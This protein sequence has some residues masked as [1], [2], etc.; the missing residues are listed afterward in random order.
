MH[1]QNI[2]LKVLLVPAIATLSLAGCMVGPRYHR[3]DATPQPPP[4]SY[5]ESPTQVQDPG[6]WKVA[7]P[8][9]AMLRVKWWEIYN[10]PELNG[11][12]DQ[13]NINNQNIKQYFENFMEARTL[14]AQAR[15][16]L[17]PTLGVGPSYTISRS[18]ANLR[19]AIS[20][21]TTSSGSSGS[22]TSTPNLHS[23][24]ISLPAEVTWEP[25]LWGKVRNTIHEA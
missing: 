15:S 18:S 16:Q 5:K 11:L 17:F 10:D 1:M 21:T 12:E 6:P 22:T 2:R 8:Q 4:P 20:A 19:N 3:P 23:T 13:L 24:L 7:Q 9:D 25:D 14:I